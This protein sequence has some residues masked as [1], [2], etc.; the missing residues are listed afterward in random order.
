M[1]STRRAL[2]SIGCQSPQH[3]RSPR[4]TTR[5]C[6]ALSLTWA[7]TAALASGCGRGDRGPERVVVCGTVTYNGKP[8]SDGMIRFTPAPT[9]R[10]P[11]TITAIVDGKYRADSRGGVP[12]GTHEIKIEG[13][14]KNAAPP[15]PSASLAPG[16]PISGPSQQSLPPKYNSNTPMEITIPSGSQEITKNFDLTD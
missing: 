10:A 8:I 2:T 11:L 4:W 9:C 5:G 14:C 1:M 16:L 13:N 3:T 6:L 7:L 15:K 12:V